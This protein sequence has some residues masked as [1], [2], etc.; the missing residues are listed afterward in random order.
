M[1]RARFAGLN[2]ILQVGCKR[3][4]AT[5]TIPHHPTRHS[6]ALEDWKEG[7]SR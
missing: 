6:T 7:E 5:G 3:E 2:V 1:E 4:K